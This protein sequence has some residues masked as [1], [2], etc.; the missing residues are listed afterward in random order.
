MGATGIQFK[1]KMLLTV[2]L[3]KNSK[4]RNSEN[5]EFRWD[6]D[7]DEQ[8]RKPDDPDDGNHRNSF[9]SSIIQEVLQISCI[10][11]F[12]LMEKTQSFI[13]SKFKFGLGRV[14]LVIPL[15][16]YL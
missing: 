16:Y 13:P 3:M 2:K 1:D 9:R 6:K 8:V 7:N 12:L 15:L 11:L 14:D 4:V 5:G 10:K